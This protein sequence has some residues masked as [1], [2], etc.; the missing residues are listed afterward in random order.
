MLYHVTLPASE[1]GNG[2]EL[3]QT[4]E[5]EAMFCLHL[6]TPMIPEIDM[7]FGE[8]QITIVNATSK[9][10]NMVQVRELGMEEP[11]T[12]KVLSCKG[13]LPRNNVIVEAKCELQPSLGESPKYAY[14]SNHGLH[15]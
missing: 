15:K 11:G 6:D 14:Q 8:R 5:K 2:I 12:S 9:A 4:A 7:G 3:L 1:G 13:T 10:G